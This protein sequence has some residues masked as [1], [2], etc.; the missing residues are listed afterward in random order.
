MLEAR[1][2]MQAKVEP[3]AL[4]YERCHFCGDKQER[5]FIMVA[6]AGRE[7]DS[8]SLC[9]KCANRLVWILPRLVEEMARK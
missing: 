5:W 1:P 3:V 7:E 6:P 8:I 4:A 9:G 2:I